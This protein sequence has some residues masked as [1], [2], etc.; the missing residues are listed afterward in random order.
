MNRKLSCNFLIPSGVNLLYFWR[1][2]K[3]TSILSST[4]SVGVMMMMMMIVVSSGTIINSL[5]IT[6]I[7]TKQT[8][9]VCI[10]SAT[11]KTKK[12][13]RDYN[14]ALSNSKYHIQRPKAKVCW[15]HCKYCW[16]SVTVIQLLS[17][18][19]EKTRIVQHLFSHLFCTIE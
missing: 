4:L 16:F 6:L 11:L 15:K 1:D 5:Y 2:M 19:R 8:S 7:L 9:E 14:L 10:V 18:Y 3:K 12:A 13:H 17:K